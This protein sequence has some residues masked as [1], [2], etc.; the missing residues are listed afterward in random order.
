MPDD[1]L[2]PTDWHDQ[3]IDAA[4]REVAGGETPPDLS[5]QITARMSVNEPVTPASLTER[6][7]KMATE[8]RNSLRNWVLVASVLMNLGLAGWLLSGGPQRRDLADRELSPAAEVEMKPDWELYD[9]G[10]PNNEVK[11]MVTPQIIAREEP[12]DSFGEMASPI[13][14]DNPFAEKPG[15]SFNAKSLT[16]RDESET[17]SFPPNL[18]QVVA[19]TA[20]PDESSI[21]DGGGQ[22]GVVANAPSEPLVRSAGSPAPPPRPTPL[23]ATLRDGAKVY[24]EQLYSQLDRADSRSAGVGKP[25]SGRPIAEHYARAADVEYV[26]PEPEEL[27]TL[28]NEYSL[29]LRFATPREES[30]EDA[31]IKKEAEG[32]GPGQGGDQYSRITE[33]PFIPAIGGNAVSTFSID[34]DTASYAN[35]RQFLLDSGTLPP[36]DA[37]RLEEL[38][39]YFHYDYKGRASDSEDPFAAHVEVAGCPWQPE[40]R[41]VRIGIKGR[42]IDPAKRPKSNLV[43]L[44][45]V[46]GSMDEPNKL[47]LVVH[48]MKQL[49]KQLGENDRVAIVV[50]ASSEGLVLESTPGDNQ[51]AII[52]AL[53]RLNAGGSTAGGAGINLAYQ[54]AE[55]NFIEGG[56]NRVILCTDGDFNVGTT[57]TADLERM[58]EQKAKDTKV[59]LSVIGF[60]RG[61]LNDEMMEKISGIGN[62][63]YYYVD[64]DR[65][66][67]KVF[68]RGMTGM[69]VTIAK[70]VKIQVEFN[71]AEVAGYR[72]LGYEN[73]MLATEDFNDDTKDAGEIGSGHTVTA[74]YQVVPAGQPVDSP[75]VDPLKYQRDTLANEVAKESGELLT[76]KMRYK[77]PDADSSVK[78]EWPVK[79]TGKS[80]K[81]ADSDMQFASAVAGF[82]M[83]LRDSRYRGDAT[84]AGMR[85]IAGSSLGNDP[86][87]ERSEFLQMVTRALEL[88]G[89]PATAA[90]ETPTEGNSAEDKSA[91]DKS[92]DETGVDE[93]AES[94]S[95]DSNEPAGAATEENS[96][97]PTPE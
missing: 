5:Q 87:G 74:L 12:T 64:G 90:G 40:H 72:L 26:L 15:E 19:A 69:L 49:A 54:I 21:P 59:F 67:E 75:E 85:E 95:A 25:T 58:V 33:N 31:G 52:G 78:R 14:L 50:Y 71:P 17:K 27:A 34:V 56:T 51:A 23:P 13:E 82:G 68:V 89:E 29:G 91:E 41:L 63:N 20:Q 93:S 30:F 62:G 76:L 84:F 36:P 83:L 53:E 3:L 65:E 86:N 7:H 48:G 39:N 70:D 46:S 61:N 11:M 35:V 4:L 10:L 16:G 8:S 96:T 9:P 38:V 43:F 73:R 77:Q 6:D 22:P 60:G 1:N 44:I 2:P 24:Y 94:E 37:V 79:D 97:V 42:E 28:S 32:R 55:E 45:D 47:P 92:V 80:F 57:S 66:A 88:K 81:E 18:A